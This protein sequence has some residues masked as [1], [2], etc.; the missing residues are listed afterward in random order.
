M[1]MQGFSPLKAMAL[2]SSLTLVT[3]VG[4]ALGCLFGELIVEEGVVA[5]QGLAAG[6]MLTMI[7]STMVPEACSHGGPR[8]TGLATLGGFVSALLFKFAE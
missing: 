2:W 6:A 4:A 3:A 8:L 7:A 5:I 1:M